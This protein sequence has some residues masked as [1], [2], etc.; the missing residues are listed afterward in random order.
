MLRQVAAI[1][2]VVLGATACASRQ[3][4]QTL[5]SLASGGP[6]VSYSQPATIVEAIG[7]RKYAGYVRLDYGE[8][9][10]LLA[11]SS[12]GVFAL[13][14][15]KAMAE[16]NAGGRLGRAPCA[17]VTLELDGEPANFY[18]ASGWTI[19][20]LAQKSLELIRAGT[21]FVPGA[22]GTAMAQ[23]SPVMSSMLWAMYGG[24]F[25]F[26]GAPTLEGCEA[27][28]PRETKTLIDGRCQ[29]ALLS[30]Y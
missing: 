17:T 1:A 8:D 12:A 30:I 11:T 9:G 24:V 5:G 15:N 26:A 18:V 19:R 14:C 23:S 3:S 28:R 22:A 2:L 13:I 6:S 27:L 16:W 21:G 29:P 7:G 10:R 25:E 20:P 4:S